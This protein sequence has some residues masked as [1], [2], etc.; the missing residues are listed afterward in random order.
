[1]LLT[2]ELDDG[3]AISTDRDQL[4]PQAIFKFMQSTYWG[5]SRSFETVKESLNNSLCFG[6]YHHRHQIGFA[7]ILTD[8]STVAYLFDVYILPNHQNKGLGTK[9]VKFIIEYPPIKNIH[10]A[11]ATRDQHHFYQAIG[12]Q[13][14]PH[15]ER[16]MVLP[17]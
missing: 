13:H 11:L 7:R 12:F 4:D 1:M 5:N 9:L 8:Y 2:S 17:R 10:I 14:H 16:I 3:Y 15:P 6:V